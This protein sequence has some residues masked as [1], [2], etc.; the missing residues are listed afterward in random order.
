MWSYPWSTA[1][2]TTGAPRAG[3][4]ASPPN[5][6]CPSWSTRC[7]CRAPNGTALLYFDTITHDPDV[8]TLLRAHA[9]PER[10]VCGSDCPFDMARAN[11]R[12]IPRP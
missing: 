1:G 11:L 3:S 9:S 4:S 5:W 7:S 10:I 8:L 6:T 2:P 12:N